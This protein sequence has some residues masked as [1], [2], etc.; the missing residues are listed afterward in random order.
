MKRYH[1]L[2]TYLHR[3]FGG[4]VQ[5]IPLDAGFSCPNRDGTLSR[6]GCIFC[7][8]Q[9]AGTGLFAQG[10]SLKQQWERWTTQLGPKYGTNM[11]L[12]Y[13]QSYSNTYGPLARLKNTFDQLAGLPGLCGV[14]IGTRPD[15]LDQEKIQYLSSLPTQEVWLDL[16]L[17]SC[18]N[19]TLARINRGHTAEDFARATELASEHG[20][21]V[22]AHLIMGLPGEGTDEFLESITFVNNLPIAGIKLHN[23]IVFKDTMLEKMWAKEE[24]RLPELAEYIEAVVFALEQLR[25]EIVVHRLGADCNLDELVAPMW[26]LKKRP[27][28]NGVNAM[29]KDLDSWQGKRLAPNSPMPEW[30]QTPRPEEN[31]S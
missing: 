22:C 27:I 4:R 18:H 13:L 15:C 10:Y 17:Q 7:N 11:F 30:F 3:R 2:S 29:L 31:R 19:T 6:H 9:G 8:E 14:C 5:K 23:M 1:S 16:G 26:A 28:M 20:L 25:P 12:A 21:K 24:M